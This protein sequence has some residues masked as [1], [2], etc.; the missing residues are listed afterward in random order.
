MSDTKLRELERRAAGGDPEAAAELA[1]AQQRNGQLR[2][3]FSCCEIGDWIH[4]E[5][6]NFSDAGILRAV[7][8]DEMGRA[9]A[10]LDKVRRRRNEDDSGPQ[11]HGDT[12]NGLHIPS[13]SVTA[14]QRC[15]DR[16]ASFKPW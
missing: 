1:R 13:T 11:W 10:V 8:L 3:V 5:G 7:F 14:T 4:C 9:I 2:S 15:A 12:G 6:P 16:W